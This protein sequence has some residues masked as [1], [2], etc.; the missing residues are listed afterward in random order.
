MARNVP[1][2]HTPVEETAIV[3]S[4]RA[5]NAE[6]GIEDSNDQA[7]AIVAKIRER[8]SIQA[9]AAILRK[10][11]HKLALGETPDEEYFAYYDYVEQCK[12]EVKEEQENHL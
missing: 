6:R 10:A 4:V 8:Y 2:K 9:E 3:A 1:V 11:I 12:A 7:K 5:E